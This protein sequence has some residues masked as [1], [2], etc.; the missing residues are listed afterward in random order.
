[1]AEVLSRLTPLDEFIIRHT[2]KYRKYRCICGIIKLIRETE[3]RTGRVKSCGCLLRESSSQRMKDRH[4]SGWHKEYN[5]RPMELPKRTKS[6]RTIETR[7]YDNK[8]KK[9]ND[10]IFY[11]E[12]SLDDYLQLPIT[13]SI[14]Y[15]MID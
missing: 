10:W 5:S 13:G 7:T 12:L 11:Q 2:N 8:R 3:V 15:R 4:A 6:T 14:E 9:F 1:M